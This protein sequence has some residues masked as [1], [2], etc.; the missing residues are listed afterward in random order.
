MPSWSWPWNL[1]PR[2]LTSVLY[3]ATVMPAKLLSV[4]A[5]AATMFAALVPPSAVARAAPVSTM[6]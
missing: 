6:R 5:V 2:L 1:V 4:T 3:C